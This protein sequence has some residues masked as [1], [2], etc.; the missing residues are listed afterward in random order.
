MSDPT[1]HACDHIL[2][3][4]YQFHDHELTEAEADEIREHLLACEPCLDRY[5]VEQALRMLIRRCCSGQSAPESLRLRIRTTITRT[6]IVS[7]GG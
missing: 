6:V 3:R 2:D 7:D 4:L 5:D 1:S